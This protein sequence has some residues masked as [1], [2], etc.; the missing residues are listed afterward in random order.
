MPL[1]VGLSW[2]RPSR[3]IHFPGDHPP[4][5]KEEKMPKHNTAPMSLYDIIKPA[6]YSFGNVYGSRCI[7]GGAILD[8]Y[9]YEYEYENLFIHGFFYK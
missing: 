7:V 6:T 9:E 1:R 2:C 5:C 4:G 3:G 8:L